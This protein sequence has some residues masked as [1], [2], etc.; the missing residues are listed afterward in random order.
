MIDLTT[1]NDDQANKIEMLL[2]MLQNSVLEMIESDRELANCP[3]LSDRL[4]DTL[5]TNAAWLEEIYTLVYGK[6]INT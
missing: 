2:L 1:I 6:E 3:D 4:R 5:N